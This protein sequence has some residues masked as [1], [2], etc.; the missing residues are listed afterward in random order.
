MLLVLVFLPLLSLLGLH[1]LSNET[2][3]ARATHHEWQ[4]TLA[5]S[6]ALQALNYIE[7]QLT[8]SAWLCFISPVPTI[9]LIKQPF[10]W[11]QRM[12]CA[13]EIEDIHYYF[14]VEALGK[15]ECGVAPVNNVNLTVKYYRITLLALPDKLKGAKITLQTTVALST[16][17][18]P[19]CPGKMRTVMLGRQMQRLF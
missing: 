5:K 16:G 4:R 8:Q 10:F 6:A 3:R 11:W 12:A 7:E 18:R 15:D 9:T 1:G 2:K 17:E 14:V 19:S 13:G